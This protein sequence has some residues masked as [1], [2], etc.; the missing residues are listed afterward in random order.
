M[1]SVFPPLFNGRLEPIAY[2]LL[3]LCFGIIMVTHGVPKLLGEAHGSMADPLAASANLIGN[4]LHLPAAD[5]LALLVALLEG[6][7]GALLA[8]GLGT[9]LLAAMMAVQMAVISYLLGPTWPWIDRGIEYPVLMLF[10]AGYIVFRGAG[11]YSLDHRLHCR[12]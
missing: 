9:R 1:P 12:R 11:R 4:V 8:L 7:G 5:T 6:V 10:L 2:S 3:R